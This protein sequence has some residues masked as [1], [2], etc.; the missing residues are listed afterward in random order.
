MTDN[1]PNSYVPP[2]WAAYDYAHCP[3]CNRRIRDFDGNGM[4]AIDGQRWC[5]DHAI[6]FYG[7]Y[8]NLP[9]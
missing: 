2:A 6:D 3:T 8:D 9:L 1:T 5:I 7:S 4:E